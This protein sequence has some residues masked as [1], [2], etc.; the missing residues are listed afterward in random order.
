MALVFNI[1]RNSRRL[2]TV[3]EEHVF[4]K[5]QF[6]NNKMLRQYKHFIVFV[7]FYSCYSIAVSRVVDKPPNIVFILTD[8]QDVVLGGLVSDV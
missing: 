6:W 4:L 8:D 3:S 7:A 5:F 1:T 2:I